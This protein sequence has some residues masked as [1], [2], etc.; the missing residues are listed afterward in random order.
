[1]R[2]YTDHCNLAYI[3]KPEASVSSVPKTTAQRLENWKMVLAQYDYM[4]MHTSDERICWGDLL[5]RRVNVA[6][7]V[8]GAVAVFASSAPDETMPSRGAF[9]E[10]QQQARAGLGA[11]ISG[12]SLFTT[13]VGR[14]TKDSDDLFRVVLDGRDVL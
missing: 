4:I 5:S 6:A 8:V 14:V 13:P 10:V 9:R 3:F 12:A 1:M 11:M 2:I 7:V